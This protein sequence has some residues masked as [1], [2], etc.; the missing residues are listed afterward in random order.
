[1]ALKSTTL[2]ESAQRKLSSRFLNKVTSFATNQIHNGN[3]SYG[4]LSQGK[5]A[6]D[7]QESND[8]EVSEMPN[9]NYDSLLKELLENKMKYEQKCTCIFLSS[10]TAATVSAASSALKAKPFENRYN[11]ETIEDNRNEKTNNVLDP[12]AVVFTCNHNLP[13]YYMV[14]VVLPEFKQR[15]RELPQPL[16]QTTE[17]LLRH[18]R[19]VKTRLFAA[20]P[21]CLY[22]YLRQEQLQLLQEAGGELSGNKSTVWQM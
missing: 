9:L 13:R 7:I 12:D 5:D 16:P 10:A 8:K 20:C 18:Y 2:T 19:Q 22:N 1:M 17:L 6:E 21:C 4:F 15:M 11:G 3:T 14:D